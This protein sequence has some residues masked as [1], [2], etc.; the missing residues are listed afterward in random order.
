MK[1]PL[2]EHFQIT[3]HDVLNVEHELEKIKKSKPPPAE[4]PLGIF[5]QVVCLFA[6]IYFAREIVNERIEN[7]VFRIIAGTFGVVFVMGLLAKFMLAMKP[8]FDAET[9]ARIHELRVKQE[10][11]RKFKAERSKWNYFNIRSGAGYW[12]KLRGLNLEKATAQLFQENG[13][14]V[15]LTKRVG[16]EGIDL[17]MFKDGKKILAQCKGLKSKL[18]VGAIR[19]AVGVQS[20]NPDAEMY[21]ICPMGFTAPSQTLA[22]EGNIKLWDADQLVS[23]VKY[24]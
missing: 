6:T 16:D 4:S 18:G 19:D 3:E 2:P 14:Q 10:S 5:F 21:V 7:L 24:D 11:V 20:L 12:Q 17:I 22:S 13:Y 9:V 23:L 1:K 15:Q 8:D